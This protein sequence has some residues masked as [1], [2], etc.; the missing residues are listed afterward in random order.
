MP[1]SNTKPVGRFLIAIVAKATQQRH[2]FLFDYKLTELTKL[3]FVR[4]VRPRLAEFDCHHSTLRF[5]VT[6]YEEHD[7]NT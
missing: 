5:L 2:L 6:V 7:P 4:S 3:E 1:K